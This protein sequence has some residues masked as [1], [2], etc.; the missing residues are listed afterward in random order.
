MHTSHA[1]PCLNYF[2]FSILYENVSNTFNVPFYKKKKNWLL[3]ILFQVVFFFF[4]E[5]VSPGQ[6]T[7]ELPM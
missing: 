2:F 1:L 3:F 5:K 7:L 6:T 4:L